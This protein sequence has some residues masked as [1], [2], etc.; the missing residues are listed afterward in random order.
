MTLQGIT[1]IGS[2][3]PL[4]PCQECNTNLRID[5]F[6]TEPSS[7]T[8]LLPSQYEATHV[9]VGQ[10]TENSKTNVLRIDQWID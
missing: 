5:N 6:R 8:Q 9:D 2:F 3:P 1:N 7:I 10:A 4:T